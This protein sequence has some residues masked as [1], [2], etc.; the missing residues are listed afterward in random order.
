M[1][2]RKI[3]P[4]QAKCALCNYT[5]SKTSILH[6]HYSNT[7]YKRKKLS[8]TAPQTKADESLPRQ[9]DIPED[10]AVSKVAGR[11]NDDSISFH[12]NFLSFLSHTHD[13][14]IMK[15]VDHSGRSSAGECTFSAEYDEDKT[16]KN[17]QS[18]DKQEN[19]NQRHFDSASESG[20]R[21]PKSTAGK[22]S[23]MKRLAK[24]S[25]PSDLDCH[26]CKRTFVKRSAML[27][28]YTHIHFK[29][30][31]LEQN[32]G[33][34][35]HCT[36]C[37]K[38]S[39][40]SKGM[41]VGHIGLVH[42]GAQKL[43]NCTEHRKEAKPK[44]NCKLCPYMATKESS[45]AHHLSMTHFK[46]Q[47]LEQMRH[48]DFI[49]SI[50]GHESE[51]ERRMIVH[52][53][54]KHG[55]NKKLY[56][57]ALSAEEQVDPVD[58]ACKICN[59]NFS[60]YQRSSLSQHYSLIHFREQIAAQ[61]VDMEVCVH[62]GYQ[63]ESER[64]M[65]L[66]YGRAHNWV[67][68]LLAA[69]PDKKAET[70]PKIAG[71]G[72]AME[73]VDNGSQA[74]DDDD[75]NKSSKS[76]KK[77][78][79]ISDPDFKLDCDQNLFNA[80]AG[81]M[82]FRCHICNEFLAASSN[83]SA[84]YKHF[85]LKHFR[86]ELHAT[87]KN[88]T[89]CPFCPKAL[90]TNVSDN[91]KHVGV[92]HSKVEDYLPK[93][94]HIPSL[95][96]KSGKDAIEKRDEGNNN[97]NSLETN[98]N[99]EESV[100][101]KSSPFS[102]YLCDKSGF[103]TRSRLYIHFSLSHFRKDLEEQI[104]QSDHCQLC[105]RP[106]QP[107]LHCNIVHLGVTHSQVD[108][109]LPKNRQIRKVSK[110]NA[111]LQSTDAS[112]NSVQNSFNSSLSN[113]LEDKDKVNYVVVYDEFVKVEVTESNED[114]LG[115]EADKDF[116]NIECPKQ[117][118]P[119]QDEGLKFENSTLGLEM[120]VEMEES[121]KNDDTNNPPA[122]DINPLDPRENM[123]CRD[124]ETGSAVES[125][126][127]HSNDRVEKSKGNSSGQ[128]DQRNCAQV[129]STEFPSLTRSVMPSRPDVMDLRNNCFMSDSDSEIVSE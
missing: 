70:G 86:D 77:D 23:S 34:T 26:L 64:A 51:D 110:S 60:G 19:D 96:K 93:L 111:N 17:E 47:I 27:M 101:G 50:C 95:K 48:D 38:D 99:D 16:N 88:K 56:Q 87:I 6:T 68:K 67:D 121:V 115:N 46:K 25:F 97:N 106:H 65:G 82:Q 21:H 3:K 40:R 89:E 7:H 84:I 5:C 39:F 112:E 57:E 90:T 108:K 120:S 104:K 49:C 92:S 52:H 107:Q 30:K 4:N 123:K 15:S 126:A 36:I 43:L 118:E 124:F 127:C 83:R 119:T 61:I 8:A 105:Q 100:G 35:D 78:G 41:L 113:G 71:I 20:D 94:H 10:Y 13:R 75:L 76:K 79:R 72:D 54:L 73:E 18:P 98:T 44:F 42:K 91:I 55:L 33:V 69:L 32:K 53:G 22:G 11:S 58:Q 66:H 31:L 59:R 29:D 2:T 109:Y 85:A 37:G 114:K 14:M 1:I 74:K 116:P 62:C 117:P 45:F 9:D 63:A 103:L 24:S 125:E 12:H 128:R 81:S 102:C 80:N 28:H 122:S 129:S